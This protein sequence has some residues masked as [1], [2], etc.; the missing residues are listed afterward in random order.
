[1]MGVFMGLGPAIGLGASGRG[2]S[3]R[4]PGFVRPW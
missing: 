4:V 3:G 2:R 1:M